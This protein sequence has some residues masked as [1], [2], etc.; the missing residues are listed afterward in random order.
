MR[1][2]TGLLVAA[3]LAAG[4]GCSDRTPTSPMATTASASAQ[5]AESPRPA[6]VARPRHATLVEPRAEPLPEGVW[7]SAEASL[8]VG[9]NGARLEIL[10]ANLPSGA[11]FGKYGDIIQHVPGGR[12]SLPGTFT[13]LIGAYP[14]KIQY[15]AAYTGILLGDTLSLTVSVPQLKQSFGPYFLVRGVTNSWT[16]CLYP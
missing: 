13:Q 6:P 9:K 10:S 8:S 5:E 16:P 14:G 4:I 15:P 3:G 11:C 7:G 12:F 1:K 2:L